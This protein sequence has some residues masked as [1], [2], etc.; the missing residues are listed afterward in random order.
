MTNEKMNAEFSTSA[1]ADKF[2]TLT[3]D[4]LTKVVGGSA[5]SILEGAGEVFMIAY[6]SGAIDYALLLL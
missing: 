6:E 5:K 3:N 2:D 4:E 1:F